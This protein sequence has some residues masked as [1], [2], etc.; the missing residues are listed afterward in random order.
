MAAKQS[1]RAK[2]GTYGQGSIY[3]DDARGLWIGSV[4]VGLKSNGRRDRKRVTA[5]SRDAMLKKLRDVQRAQDDGL[6]IASATL[7]TAKWLDHWVRTIAPI[8]APKSAGVYADVLRDWVLPY[9]GRTPLATFQPE[10]FEQLLARLE[11]RGLSAGSRQKVRQVL[12]R[13][14][15]IALRRGKVARNP[16][17]LVQATKQ[18]HRVSDA[19]TADQARQVMDAAA[20]D[21]LEALAV[22]VLSL[23]ARQGEA[24]AARWDDVDLDAGVWIIPDAKTAAGVRDLPLPALVVDALRGHLARQREERMR[25]D[26]WRDPGLIFATSVG[27]RIDRRNCLRWWHR[28]T[29]QAGVGRRRFHASRHTAA[30]VLLN[31]DVPL[32]VVSKILGHSRLAITSDIYAKPGAAKLRG[33]ANAVDAIYG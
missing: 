23:G 14:F 12:H 16:I 6:P 9:I 28:L 13:A 3:F 18:P 15:V 19:L 5:K 4:E 17:A 31:A 10:H 27:S 25:A 1:K 32:E 30:T 29:T 8:S 24:L 21:R 22:L 2:R 26:T 7:T 33:A 11:E 20:G